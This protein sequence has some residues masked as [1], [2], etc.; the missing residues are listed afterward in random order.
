MD[1]SQV[2]RSFTK[3]FLTA[4]FVLVSLLAHAESTQKNEPKVLSPAEAGRIFLRNAGNFISTGTESTRALSG[5]VITANFAKGNFRMRHNFHPGDMLLSW[6]ALSGDEKGEKGTVPYQAFEV[7]PGVFFLM[8]QPTSHE[9]VSLII[10]DNRGVASGFLSRYSEKDAGQLISQVKI[11]GEILEST[12][13]EK[14][15]QLAKTGDLSGTRFTVVYPNEVAIYEHI[16]LNKHY[17][18]W[19]GHKGTSAGVADTERYEA[20]ELAPLLYLVAWNEKS[21]PLQI[22]MLF[23]FANK[24]ERA[25]IFGYDESKDRTVYQTTSAKI[26]KVSHTNIQGLK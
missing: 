25:T 14:S 5:R 6:E 3:S 20:I 17:L 8:T 10:D 18:T 13:E 22:S 24:T 11:H 16:Y 4:V 15:R 7:R 19:L 9:A 12:I 2:Y 26:T 1:L 23:D 21:A